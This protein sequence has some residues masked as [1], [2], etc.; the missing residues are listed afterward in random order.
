MWRFCTYLKG[1]AGGF[2]QFFPGPLQVLHSFWGAQE[3]LPSAI[4]AYGEY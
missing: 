4:Y 1:S 2:L 3:H